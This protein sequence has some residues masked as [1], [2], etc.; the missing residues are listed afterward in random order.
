MSDIWQV[1]LV[2]IFGIRNSFHYL[3]SSILFFSG[4]DWAALSWVIPAS[5]CGSAESESGSCLWLCVKLCSLCSDFVPGTDLFLF[6]INI[7]IWFFLRQAGFTAADRCC[8]LELL[9]V[10]VLGMTA[11]SEIICFQVWFGI[12]ISI[13]QSVIIGWPLKSL[14]V[15]DKCLYELSFISILVFSRK[16]LG[17]WVLG[18]M[19]VR[20]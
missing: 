9:T 2:V 18:E 14:V 10:S 1:K 6:Q 3:V 19:C 17:P 12:F 15:A 8:W 13:F 4:Q 16:L 5:V 11:G 20:F 7:Y